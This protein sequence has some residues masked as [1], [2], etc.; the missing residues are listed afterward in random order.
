MTQR[1]SQRGPLPLALASTPKVPSLR[2]TPSAVQMQGTKSRLQDFAVAR[3][4]KCEL[5]R[6]EK[7]TK[8]LDS[9]PL[10]RT[11][12][13][14]TAFALRSVENYQSKKGFD[15]EATAPQTSASW[16]S[17]LWWTDNSDLVV[18]PD[19]D[20]TPTKRNVE[21]FFRSSLRYGEG[22][23]SILRTANDSVQSTKKAE[24]GVKTGHKSLL[25]CR[26]GEALTPKSALRSD[27]AALTSKAQLVL[28]SLRCLPK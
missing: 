25:L 13:A 7:G 28:S 2:S 3:Q 15:P 10:Q 18:T 17:A 1:H 21:D 14:A 6:Q 19:R 4:R 26:K 12:T 9:A 24:C 20:R 22:F 5:R 27:R 8:A 11:I 16:D 23:T